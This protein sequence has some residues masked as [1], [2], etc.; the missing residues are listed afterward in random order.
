[1][2]ALAFSSEQLVQLALALLGLWGIIWAIV[3]W[4]CLSKEQNAAVRAGWA[5]AVA[6]GVLPGA[7]LY[8]VYR[9]PQRIAELGE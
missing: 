3:L 8:L 9:R 7:L 1:M 5:Y 4:E 2:L 6:L